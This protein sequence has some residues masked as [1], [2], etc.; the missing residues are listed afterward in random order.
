MYN[1]AE[2]IIKYAKL[3]CADSCDASFYKLASLRQAFYLAFFSRAK[4]TS[5]PRQEKLF[6][7]PPFFLI[8]ITNVF[9]AKKRVGHACICPKMVTGEQ[10]L[11]LY[12]PPKVSLS[13][14]KKVN[15]FSH[16]KR[17]AHAHFWKKSQTQFFS[18]SF[19]AIF[20]V[21]SVTPLSTAREGALDGRESRERRDTIL[22]KKFRKNR[23]NAILA[24]FFPLFWAGSL[25]VRESRQST[26]AWQNFRQKQPK[27]KKKKNGSDIFFSKVRVRIPFSVGKF[28][29]FLAA[30]KLT[31]LGGV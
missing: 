22:S 24:W 30:E 2:S 13:A 1:I 9:C 11:K 20:V 6:I 21:N 10:V 14:A 7:W 27:K 12:H 3:Y 26:S 4:C 25:V 28:H 31:F 18:S 8:Y 17:D 23:K 16:W 15:K 5:S 19:S 29:I